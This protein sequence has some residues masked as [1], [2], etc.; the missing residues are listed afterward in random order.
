MIMS[1]KEPDTCYPMLA[2][3]DHLSLFAACPPR[4]G[5]TIL[6]VRHSKTRT[7]CLPGFFATILLVQD[8]WP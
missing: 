3:D 4:V 6:L 7:A 1:A 8:H 2:F 5:L